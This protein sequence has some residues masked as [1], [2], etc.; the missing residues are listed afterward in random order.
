MKDFTFTFKR[1]KWTVIEK[2]DLRDDSGA[3]CNGL[4]YYEGHTIHLEKNLT[5]RDHEVMSIKNFNKNNYFPLTM[6][7]HGGIISLSSERTT[8]DFPLAAAALPSSCLDAR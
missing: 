8:F 1:K 5:T 6:E 2:E 7:S 4:T 3:L